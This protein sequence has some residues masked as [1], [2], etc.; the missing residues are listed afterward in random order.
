MSSDFDWK[1]YLYFALYLME[2]GDIEPN[3]QAQM[4]TAVSRAYY[5]A[6][7]IAFNYLETIGKI[8]PH[9]QNEANFHKSV[10][11]LFR[12]DHDKQWK[13]IGNNLGKLRIQ[14]NYADYDES[15]HFD[16]KDTKALTLLAKSVIERLE[17]FTR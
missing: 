15:Y 16:S 2:Q 7:K 5:A 12:D 14:R 8:A 10:K 11:D 1:Q 13:E 4:R 3:K 6:F 17:Q 9:Q